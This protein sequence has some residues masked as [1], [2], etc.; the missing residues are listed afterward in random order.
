MVWI[1][2]LPKT[3]SFYTDPGFFQVFMFW[4]LWWKFLNFDTKCF[5]WSPSLEALILFKV[6]K[7]WKVSKSWSQKISNTWSFEESL[8][9]KMESHWVKTQS[10]LVFKGLQNCAPNSLEGSSQMLSWYSSWRSR[11]MFD[12]EWCALGARRGSFT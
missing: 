12:V 7:P 11:K 5:G 2:S 4:Q 6:L 10:L 1:S 8:S 3:S 9:L